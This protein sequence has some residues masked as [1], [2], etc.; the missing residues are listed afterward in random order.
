[1]KNKLV[2]TLLMA[3]CMAVCVT[4]IL[5][6]HKAWYREPEQ[7]LPVKIQMEEPELVVKAE[8]ELPVKTE[9]EIKTEDHLDE[10]PQRENAKEQVLGTMPEELFQAEEE[11]PLVIQPE[12]VTDVES[13]VQELQPEPEKTENEKPEDAPTLKENA[14]ITKP[15]VPPAYE[16]VKEPAPVKDTP[17]HGATKDGMIY[18]DGFGWI[19]NQGG[20][21]SGTTAEDMYENGNKVGTM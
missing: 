11:E 15:D 5:G 8:P 12:P 14:E 4:A 9:P 13:G 6:I 3:G 1:M 19:P 10:V 2:K 21:G 17:T 16:E 7:K 18:I 20:G